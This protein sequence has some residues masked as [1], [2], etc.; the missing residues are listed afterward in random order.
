MLRSFSTPKRN[1]CTVSCLVLQ[2]LQ[3][4]R[5]EKEITESSSSSWI[6]VKVTPMSPPR[7]ELNNSRKSQSDDVQL[8]TRNPRQECLMENFQ[9]LTVRRARVTM[10]GSLLANL[11]LTHAIR[12]RDASRGIK[13]LRDSHGGDKEKCNCY[14]RNRTV[15]DDRNR[16]SND[17]ATSSTNWIVG[18]VFLLSVGIASCRSSMVFVVISRHQDR[19]IHIFPEREFYGINLLTIS[20]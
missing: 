13:E 15:L 19:L 10:Y 17:R 9:N 12:L 20:Y 3:C 16:Q 8:L 18:T 14:E 6:F 2:C 1:F 4:L 5:T 7:M 11:N